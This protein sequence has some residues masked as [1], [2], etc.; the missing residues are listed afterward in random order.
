MVVFH[1]RDL[2]WD[3][4]PKRRRQKQSYVFFLMEV[5]FQLKS[6]EKNAYFAVTFLLWFS[7]TVKRK[8]AP[9]FQLDNDVQTGFGRRNSLCKGVFETELK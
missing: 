1:I 4:I 8:H 5:R 2:K 7:Q 6:M 9:L 3:K